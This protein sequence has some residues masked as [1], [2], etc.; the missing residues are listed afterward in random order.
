MN[1]RVLKKTTL[2]VQALSV[3]LAVAA[4]VVLPQLCHLAG[5]AAGV[6]NGLGTMLL[7]MHLG[8]LAVG[9][10]V[11]PWAGLA[12]GLISPVISFGLTGM[13]AAV[14]LPSMTVELAVYGLTAGWLR[15]NRL[16]VAGKVLLAQI[17]GRLVKAG[18]LALMVYGFGQTAVPVGSVWT[19]T[20]QGLAGI[21]LQLVLIPLFVYRV[22]SADRD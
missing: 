21:L 22:R 3:L 12:T 7:P 2:K 5:K 4:S 9:L 15:G 1:E 20:V 16:P 17:A 18:F 6:E 14:L 11:G 13:P 10:L 8:V 19:A